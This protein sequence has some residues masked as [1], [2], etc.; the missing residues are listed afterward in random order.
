MN[1]RVSVLSDLIV[2]LISLFGE[3]VNFRLN[4]MKNKEAV[5]K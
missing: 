3:L 2:V 1:R 4:A 5:I